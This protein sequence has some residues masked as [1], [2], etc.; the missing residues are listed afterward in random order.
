MVKKLLKYEF[1]AFGKSILP[2]EIILIAIA[3][4]QRVLQLFENDSTT[5]TIFNVSSIIMLVVAMIVCIVMT[6]ALCIVRFY[7][8]MFTAE[9]YLTLTLPVTHTQH[10]FA[11]LIT[12]V[13]ACVASVISVIVAG[14]IATAGD[15][16]HEI[17]K[18]GVYFL[19]LMQNEIHWHLSAYALE[20]IVL[21]IV[22]IASNFLLYYTCMTIGQ[23][24]HK[25]RVLAS[26]GV[27]FAYY[28]LTQILGTIFI[29]VF[30]AIRNTPFM[31]A[32]FN[33]LGKHP[34]GGIH[35]FLCSFIV[36]SAILGVVF[37]FITKYVM[38]HKLN[39]E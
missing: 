36:I 37:Y 4:F 14:I 21:L 9:G 28:I 34:I 20:I 24:A 30:V 33:W 1:S 31:V 2:M 16:F 6:V 17:V 15:V 23:M 13:C 7:K 8:N 19:K 27:Y 18:A 32:I 29:I 12:A 39:I 35:I 26:F 5:Y 10:I 11:K 22:A 25:N 38:K 3:A